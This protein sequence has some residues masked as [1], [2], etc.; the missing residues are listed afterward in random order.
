MSETNKD[1]IILVGGGHAHV[2]VVRQLGS[3][4]LDRGIVLVS[5]SRHTPYSGMLPGY[6]AGQYTFDEF[7]IDLAR[8]CARY[9]VSFLEAAAT[10]ID[11]THRRVSLSDGRILDYALLSLDIGSTP[12][13]PERVSGGV[14]VKPIASFTERLAQLD[15]LATRQNEPLRLAVIGQGVAGVEVAL[16]LK[17]RLDGLTEHPVEIA[18]VGRAPVLIPERGALARRIVARALEQA[19]IAHHPLFDVVGFDRGQVAARDGRRLA[20]DEVVW[21]TSSGAAGWLTNTGLSLDSAGFIRVDETLRSVSHPEIFAAGDIASLPDPR[22]KAG[23]F[24]V[25]QGPILAENIRRTIGGQPLL[26]YRPQRAWLALISLADGR[27]VADK[28]GLAASGQWVS[29]WKHRN[30]TDFLRRYR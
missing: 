26:H 10:G 11:P 5:P 18:L 19:G 17:H 13:L 22:P 23:V 6:I 12:S 8:L 24:A 7:H 30:D 20:V 9:G 25:R 2:E 27:A 15:A 3:L 16:A 1:P 29:A 4:A 21:T 14:S 28:W